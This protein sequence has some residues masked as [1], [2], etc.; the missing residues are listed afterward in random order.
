MQVRRG[1]ILHLRRAQRGPSTHWVDDEKA[2]EQT[3]SNRD[4]NPP[5]ILSLP[6]VATMESDTTTKTLANMPCFLWV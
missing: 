1:V 6:F 2:K 4:Q 5:A 3:G